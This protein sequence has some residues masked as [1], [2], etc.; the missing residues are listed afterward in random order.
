MPGQWICWN[1]FNFQRF[2][3]NKNID[4]KILFKYK[5]AFFLNSLSPSRSRQKFY[6]TPDVV[7][8]APQNFVKICRQILLSTI[9]KNKNIA[10]FCMWSQFVATIKKRRGAAMRKAVKKLNQWFITTELTRH[11]NVWLSIAWVRIIEFCF[12]IILSIYLKV[13]IY[14]YKHEVFRL[15]KKLSTSEVSR[16][17]SARNA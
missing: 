4:K 1:F 5:N 6:G 11:L 12:C 8:T 7:C 9:N 3:K 14:N 13:K 16:L 17:C 2:S 10:T 15:C